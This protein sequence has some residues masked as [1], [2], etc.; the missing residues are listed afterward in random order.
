MT[1]VT[2][3]SLRDLLNS[4]VLCDF[5]NVYISLNRLWISE[6]SEDSVPRARVKYCR[7][8]GQGEEEIFRGAKHLEHNIIL[9][10]RIICLQ[11]HANVNGFKCNANANRTQT[12]D[13][14]VIVRPCSC[15]C[16]VYE[17]SRRRR[18]NYPS[19]PWAH[20]RSFDVHI[21]RVGRVSATG[22]RAGARQ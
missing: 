16:W 20:R 2:N 19:S 22:R 18:H 5:I 15:I 4:R 11:K 12:A 9:F 13:V 1:S 17:S 21:I 10:A 14:V 7:G 3:L 6:L 8:R